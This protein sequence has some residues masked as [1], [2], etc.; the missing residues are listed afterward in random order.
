MEAAGH[1]QEGKMDIREFENVFRSAS[2]QNT[3]RSALESL[4]SRGQTLADIPDE[5]AKAIE[6]FA[7]RA[8]DSVQDSVL[9]DISAGWG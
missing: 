9:K 6:S 1:T 4:A 3:S 2:G 7:G 8:A 5:I